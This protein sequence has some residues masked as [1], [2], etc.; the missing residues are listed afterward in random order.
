[1]LRSASPG[2]GE[3]VAAG[4]ALRNTPVRLWRAGGFA[5]LVLAGVL[6]R[7]WILASP[8]GLVDGDE[9][10]VGLMARR[11]LDGHFSAFFWGQEYGGSFEAALVAALLALRVPGRVAM[12]LVP[13]GLHAA[14]AAL[15][16]RIGRRTSDRAGGA[17]LAAGICWAASPALLWWSTKER[18]FYGVTLVCG[19]AALL[20]VLRLSPRNDPRLALALGLVLGIGWWSSPQ[21]LH[22]ALPG[23]AWL[24]WS[25]RRRLGELA[26]LVATAAPAA[27]VGALPWLWANPHSG[28]AAVE[29]AGERTTFG[30]PFSVFFRDGVP[31]VLG[32]RAPITLGWELPGARVAYVAVLAGVAA[33]VVLRP[34]D[35]RPVLLAVV[36]YPVV[37]ALL[38]TTYYYGEPRYLDFL[39]PLLALVAGWA[40]SRTDRTSVHA[41]AVLVVLA[42]TANGVL[43]MTR[44]EGPPNRPFEDISPRPV[45]PLV[46]TL[47][48]LG[49]DRAFADYWVAYRLSWE[50][51]DRIVATPLQ[52][53]REPGDDGEVRRSARPAYVVGRGSCLDAQLQERLE[54]RAI[55]FTAQPVDVWDVVVPS[56]RVV[57]EDLGLTGC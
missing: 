24:A 15:V 48:R 34:R 9:A 7:V 30:S 18:G 53:V 13:I 40:L 11:M 2:D 29:A 17:E 27:V 41:A 46:A 19:L 5:L 51:E 37:F 36:A 22:F 1:L 6:F 54:A 10:V 44:L 38:P 52:F 23:L 3:A 49:V 55:A 42:V 39:W 57:P 4:S 50:T 31:M 28:L 56:E 16:W 12:E 32:L 8:L 45:A 47:D 20:L 33:V 35:L 26:R 25:Y 14:A 21:I 43:H